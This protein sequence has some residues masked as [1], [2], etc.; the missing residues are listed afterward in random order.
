MLNYS[1]EIC[2]LLQGRASNGRKA[3]VITDA[4]LAMLIANLRRDPRFATITDSEFD[5]L[6]AGTATEMERVLFAETSNHIHLDEA[7]DA[8]ISVLGDHGFVDADHTEI[9]F[10][11]NDGVEP[12]TPSATIFDNYIA[13]QLKRAR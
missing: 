11:D 9:D 13:V 12:R 4:M 7:E 2:D 5:L 3:S 10:T 8:V 6:L 1:R